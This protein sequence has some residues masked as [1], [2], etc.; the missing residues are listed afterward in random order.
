MRDGLGITAHGLQRRREICVRFWR[1]RRDRRCTTNQGLRLVGKTLTKPEDAQVYERIDMLGIGREHRL[2][3]PRSVLQPSS[4]VRRERVLKH[5][6][7]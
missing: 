2:V 7:S 6:R 5:G 3:G 1:V 4:A